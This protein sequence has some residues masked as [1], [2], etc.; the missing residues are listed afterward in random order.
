MGVVDQRPILV[1][2]EHGLDADGLVRGDGGVEPGLDAPHRLQVRIRR[3]RQVFLLGDG[4]GELVRIDD[5][6][7]AGGL[8]EGGGA[9]G[10]ALSGSV[11]PRD[12]PERRNL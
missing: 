4:L 2:G 11:G 8:V 10:A 6:D 5:P 12:D 1:G 9:I 3:Q 7:R